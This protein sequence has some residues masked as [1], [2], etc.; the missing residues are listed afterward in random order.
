MLNNGRASGAK[1]HLCS[2]GRLSA[3]KSDFTFQ[4]TDE[5]RLITRYRKASRRQSLRSS[6]LQARVRSDI[7]NGNGGIRAYAIEGPLRI[8]VP[9]MS[10]FHG[11][12]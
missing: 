6:I 5:M 4:K 8:F 11:Y 10:H 3:M 7:G 2:G 9:R 1:A 12:D